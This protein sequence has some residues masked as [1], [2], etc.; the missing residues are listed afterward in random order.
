M[1][2][3]QHVLL[4]SWLPPTGTL[5]TIAAGEHWDAAAIP[6][7]AGLAVLA[8]LH[9]MPGTPTGPVIW[10]T[11]SSLRHPQLYILTTARSGID[12]H[13]TPARLLSTGSYVVVPGNGVI[14]PHGVHWAVP[15]NPDRPDELTDPT[16]LV[17]LLRRI[18]SAAW[19][20][21]STPTGYQR[22]TLA[23]Q[24]QADGDACLHCHASDGPLSP[25]PTVT[26]SLGNT[27]QAKASALCTRCLRAGSDR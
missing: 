7:T 2:H 14:E 23:T 6:Q 3:A 15:P 25:G 20:T 13:G 9:A 17:T 11:G 16:V 18:D 5:S 26:I 12:L 8:M 21:V 22:Q 19:I 27:V 24:A 1:T 4:P 10:S